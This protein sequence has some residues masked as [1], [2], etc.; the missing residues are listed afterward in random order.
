[1]LPDLSLIRVKRASLGISQRQLAE[2]SGVSQG[3]IAK[4][5][6]GRMMPSYSIARRLF[7]SLE[8]CEKRG[9]KTARDIMTAPVISVSTDTPL[10]LA[11]RTMLDRGISQ[12]PVVEG[13]R[14]VGRI[15]ERLLLD[16]EG[17]TCR[18]AMGPPF[19]TVSPDAPLELVREMLRFEPA[20]VVASDRLEGIIA[21]NDLLKWKH[22]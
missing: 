10:E 18:D 9:E 3:T 12:L 15:T 16:A 19:P 1:M 2:L 20:I 22:L 14:Q 7:E 6:R 4:I 17:E 21:R 5:E 13:G 8:R 11:K